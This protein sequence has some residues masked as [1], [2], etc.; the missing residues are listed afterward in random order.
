MPRPG[1]ADFTY[2]K[3]Y[4]VRDYRGGGRASGRETVGRV[5]AGAIAKKLLSLKKIEIIA[6]VI[7][8]GKI[9]AK[10]RD[11]DEIKKNVEKNPVRCADMDVAILMEE[12]IMGARKEGDSIGGVVEVIA[13]G[14]P[15]GLGEPVFDKLDS[16]LAKALMSIG[17]VK[18]VEIGLGF[19][20]TD[21]L[22]SN[23]KDEFYMK[24]GD[25]RTR[26]NNAGGIL[27]GIS[28]GE[29]IVCRIAVKPTS[30]IA[31][32][33][34]TVDLV[35]MKE[36]EIEIEGRHDPCISPRIVPVAESMV[37]LVLADY[38]IISGLVPRN[39]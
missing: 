11:F 15:A 9:K 19:G 23:V 26:T 8:V 37:S 30:S 14:V 2:W 31:K 21:K 18:G 1:H 27:G 28:N 10:S 16:D 24:D 4:G 29:E 20:Y 17:A 35:E 32:P 34:K 38:M 3:K 12:K 6:H 36:R 25:V 5:A 33:Q 22:G 13:K 7:Q 39:L